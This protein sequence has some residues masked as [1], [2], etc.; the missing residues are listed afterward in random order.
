MLL[1][2]DVDPRRNVRF[3]LPFCPVPLL[4]LTF[5]HERNQETSRQVFFLTGGLAQRVIQTTGRPR[6]EF[7]QVLGGTPLLVAIHDYRP[8]LPWPLYNMTQAR[9]HLWVMRA[10]ARHLAGLQ[11][12]DSSQKLT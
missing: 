4:E 7:R 8:T 12:Q 3:R 2:V 5:A 1:R 9:L 11:L 6:L 10:F